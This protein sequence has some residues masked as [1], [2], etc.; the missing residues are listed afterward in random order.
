MGREII[1]TARGKRV[2][3][4][5]NQFPGRFGEGGEPERSWL[6]QGSAAR[7]L[8]CSVNNGHSWRLAQ[9]RTSHG[10]CQLAENQAESRIW[11]KK[12]SELGGLLLAPEIGKSLRDMHRAGEPEL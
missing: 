9:G 2:S 11:Q 7:V 8:L 3:G 5:N 4:S 10:V 6:A 1:S 12:S